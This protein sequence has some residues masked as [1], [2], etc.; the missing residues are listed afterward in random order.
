M[1]EP[2]SGSPLST[3]TRHF[4]FGFFR[5]SFLT[6]AAADSFVRLIIAGLAALFTIGLWLPRLYYK[7]YVAL[8]SLPSPELYLQA[9]AADRLLVIALSMFVVGV[10]TALVGHSLFP[11]ETDHRVL[12]ALPVTRRQI[13]WTKLGALAL[14]VGLFGAVA[15]AAT[16]PLH[17]LTL[18]GRWSAAPWYREAAA[19][20]P[21][22]VLA[23]LFAVASV[24]AV[25]GLI[26]VFAP[27][28]WLQPASIAIRTI[29]LSAAVL[30]LPFL[31]R[32]PGYYDVIEKQSSLLFA[33]PPAW[34]LG[35]ERLLAGTANPFLVRLSLA[36]AAGL[37]LAVIV[38]AGCY[39]RLY[40]RFERLVMRPP[41]EVVQWFAHH[42]RDTRPAW[43]SLPP[44][45]VAVRRFL[46]TTLGRSGVH[47]AIFV[48]G[49]AL[50]LAWVMNGLL[51]AG[52]VEWVQKGGP[53]PRGLQEAVMAAPFDL[54]FF[55]VLACRASILVPIEL[56][57]NWVFRMGDQ[58]A[59]RSDQLAG[60]DR[61]LLGLAVT[62]PVLAVLPLAW[63]VL[64]PRAILMLPVAWLIG[65]LFVEFVVSD[66]RRIP[67]TC[68]YVFGKHPLVQT[69]LVAFTIFVVFV[70]GGVILVRGA[71]ASPARLVVT[72]VV[73]AL[74]WTAAGRRR[75]NQRGQEPLEFED[76]GAGALGE[77]R[78][79]LPL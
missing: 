52:I 12:G 57:A 36:A 20:L 45:H 38:G 6:D 47:Q 66:W 11:D 10:V 53:P 41:T 18:V 56:R 26:V 21:A 62:P 74:L 49:A 13:F 79:I 51:G 68:T 59:S 31:G 58:A 42:G 19:H 35:V 29:S 32:I 40:R 73:L 4:F 30:S 75:T 60:V 48:G 70:N 61:G 50:G 25:H 55:T 17:A 3:L 39:A 5:I 14:F 54:T 71:L 15:F 7:K 46:N 72:L 44:A 24:V 28:G 9:V 43:L 2:V 69:M 67:F 76:D 63:W 64:G 33:L 23:E 37:V 27:P 65:A 8:N 1:L 34:F 78:P 16:V 22:V 77:V